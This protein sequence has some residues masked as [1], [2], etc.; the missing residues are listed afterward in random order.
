MSNTV[1]PNDHLRTV[2][3]MLYYA[4]QDAHDCGPGDPFLIDDSKTLW[5]DGDAT[6]DARKFAATVE[7]HYAAR[8]AAEIAA[9]KAQ[10]ELS[11]EQI[12]ALQNE[13]R[14]D[15]VAR[16]FASALFGVK[17]AEI[18]T[19]KAADLKADFDANRELWSKEWKKQVDERLAE[20]GADA[21]ARLAARFRKGGAED[22]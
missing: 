17:P 22:K 7:A 11:A 19:S 21:P 9:L 13:L 1:A 20:L 10:I 4:L 5:I 12:R 3:E 14:R 8:H 15:E 6:F 16:P 2:A 18:A